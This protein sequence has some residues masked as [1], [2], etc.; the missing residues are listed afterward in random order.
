MIDLKMHCS[1]FPSMRVN[2]KS[3]LVYNLTQLRKLYPGTIQIDTRDWLTTLL[4][5][6]SSSSRYYNFGRKPPQVIFD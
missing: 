3:S 5:C 2:F 6:T 4:K 1:L